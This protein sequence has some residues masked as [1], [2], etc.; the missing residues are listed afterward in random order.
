MR[1]ILKVFYPN[2]VTNKEILR[3]A[4]QI[5][6]IE[7]ITDRKWRWIGHIARKPPQHITRQILTW[8]QTGRIPRGRPRQ[9]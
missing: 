4:G 9:T 7:E 2:L 8:L 1:R 5:D 3:R 6:V